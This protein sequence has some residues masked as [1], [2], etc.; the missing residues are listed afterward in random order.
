MVKMRDSWRDVVYRLFSVPNLTAPMRP[1]D[2]CASSV[3]RLLDVE[4]LS[5]LL[6]DHP[7]SF[8]RF[9]T[10]ESGI[11]PLFPANAA[12]VTKAFVFVR[13]EPKESL[14]DMGVR[15]VTT[16]LVKQIAGQ[17]PLGRGLEVGIF[18]GLMD[19]HGILY[20]WYEGPG[21]KNVVD[22]LRQA[23]TK[24]IIRLMVTIDIPPSSGEQVAS[25]IDRISQA[26]KR[27]LRSS[28]FGVEA[29]RTLIATLKK[30]EALAWP[31]D[32][33]SLAPF[34]QVV[35]KNI[36]LEQLQQAEVPELLRSLN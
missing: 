20:Q 6:R 8:E 24:A 22:S 32:G 31:K 19:A 34:S 28:L 21:R 11:P 30:V 27:L 10:T 2:H 18:E 25:Q 1:D 13:S 3:V 15:E 29:T 9:L 26:V 7:P 16:Y 4:A 14:V 35:L 5:M 33:L 23:Y 12:L 17:Y 36:L